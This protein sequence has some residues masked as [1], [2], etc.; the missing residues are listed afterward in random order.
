MPRTK[1]TPPRRRIA[2]P[3]RRN[4]KA[5]PESDAW[6]LAGILDDVKATAIALLATLQD[7]ER[8]L[9]EKERDAPLPG[10]ERGLSDIAIL[11]RWA[12]R[13]LHTIEVLEKGRSGDLQTLLEELGQFRELVGQQ[14]S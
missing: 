1:S 12:D 11:R 4:D 2:A 8:A 3:P 13:T 6:E 7:K 14:A 9:R 5:R 10:V